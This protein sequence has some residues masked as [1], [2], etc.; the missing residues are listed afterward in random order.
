MTVVFNTLRDVA[1]NAVSGAAVEAHL[2]GGSYVVDGTHDQSTVVKSRSTTT[3]G[4]GYWQFDLE[5]TEYMPVGAVYEIREFVETTRARQ[6]KWRT[7]NITVP[8]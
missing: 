4:S 6:K 8:A 5:P 3:N 2:V 1:Q 7:T